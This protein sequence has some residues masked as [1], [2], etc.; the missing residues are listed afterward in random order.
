MHLVPGRLNDTTRTAVTNAP[1]NADNSDGE[2]GT[3]HLDA[4]H[5]FVV[6]PAGLAILLNAPADV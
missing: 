6:D 1:A 3:G 4:S 2:V 5:L